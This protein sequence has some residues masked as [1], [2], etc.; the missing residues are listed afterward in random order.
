MLIDGLCGEGL[1]S[2]DL[3][4]ADLAGSKQ[5]PEQHGG[6]VGGRQHGLRLDPAL[7]LFVEPFDRIRGTYA[8]PLALRQAREGEEPVAGFLQAVGDGFVFEPP[9]ADEGFAMLFDLF[10][11]LPALS[12]R[13]FRCSPR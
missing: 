10:R 6:G 3:A 11:P 5:R 8:A 2:I 7:E 13:S 4:H 9:L 1:P 12:R